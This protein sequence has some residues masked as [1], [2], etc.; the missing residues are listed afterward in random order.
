MFL[1][2]RKIKTTFLFLESNNL[3][4][5]PTINCTVKCM[6]CVRNEHMS[7]HAR[8]GAFSPGYPQTLPALKV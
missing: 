7:L 5:L 6:N 8:D 2:Q 3:I 1:C 4:I